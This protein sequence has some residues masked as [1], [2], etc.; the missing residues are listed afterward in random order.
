MMVM[1]AKTAAFSHLYE[2]LGAKGGEKKL[3]RLA[4]AR[5]R[6]ARDLDQ[7]RGPGY[8]ARRD[9]SSESHRDIRYCRRIKVGEVV[10]AMRKIS[11]GRA[12]GLDEIPIEF[13]RCAG[14]AGLEWLTGLFNDIFRTKRMPDEWRWSTVVPLYKKK[15]DIQSC[16]NYMGIKLLSHTMKV[17]ERV[18]EARVRKTVSVS[19]NQFGLMP[20][21]DK[22]PREVLWRCLE[23]KGVSVAY[24][25]AIKDMYDGAKT[26]VRIM[27]GDSEHFSVVMG[28]HQGSALSPF[29]FALV[30][31][32][33]THHVQGEVPWCML[34]TDDIIQI[35]E[36]RSGVNERL[37]DLRQVHLD[38]SMAC[39]LD[40][41]L[42]LHVEMPS[43]PDLQQ[44]ESFF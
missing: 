8:C 4:K 38:I 9:G 31:D 20:A 1:E 41:H 25:R 2:D 32:A 29:L 3:L 17:W 44:S 39:T 27:G 12:T 21:Y 24:I 18:V 42:R 15:G 28:L 34:L 10:G 14:K 19:D 40:Y 33:L 6:K 13:W 36:M 22:V 23:A 5:K 35:D 11:R 43:E 37:E 7:V 16:N 30:M 26:R